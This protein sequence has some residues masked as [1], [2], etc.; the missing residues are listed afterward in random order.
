MTSSA[1]SATWL[2][3]AVARAAVVSPAPAHA[4]PTT[5]RHRAPDMPGPF[6][7]ATPR[8][9]VRRGRHSEAKWSGELHDPRRDEVD[10]F[11][12]LGFGQN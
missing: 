3:A 8:D 11:D 2:P 12:W 4:V 9:L 5:G 10:A 1:S 7:F 6:T